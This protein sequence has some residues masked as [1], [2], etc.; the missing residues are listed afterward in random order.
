MHLFRKLSGNIFLTIVPFKTV[1][2][3]SLFSSWLLM[4]INKNMQCSSV[5]YHG[6]HKL[7]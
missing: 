5:W 3:S 1:T 4:H 6:T 7:G 2:C